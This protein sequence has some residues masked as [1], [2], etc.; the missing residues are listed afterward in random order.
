MVVDKEILTIKEIYKLEDNDELEIKS[1]GNITE[2]F[3]NGT[4]IEFVLGIDFNPK[5]NEM[6]EIKVERLFTKKDFDKI[7]D[8]YK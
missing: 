7:K 5:P 8:Y 4:K 1:K 2:I 6:V 3:I